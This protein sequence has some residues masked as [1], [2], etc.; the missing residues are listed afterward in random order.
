MVD[1][2]GH[3]TEGTST[4]LTASS[5]T[6]TGGTGTIAGVNFYRESNSTTGL[7]IGSDTLVGAGTASGTTW[8]IPA[9]TTGLAPGTYTFY[10]VATD[11]RFQ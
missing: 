6:E 1:G 7:Q 9:S 8:T 11:S 2:D 10:A 5:V 3:V 4:T